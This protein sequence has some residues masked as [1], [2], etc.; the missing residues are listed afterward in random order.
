M[1]GHSLSAMIGF[2]YMYTDHLRSDI[3]A[4]GASSDKVTT[5]NAAPDLIHSSTNIT[6]EALLGAF[7]RV[8]YDYDEKYLFSATFRA[9]GSSR[10]AEE[11]RWGFFPGG[12]AAWVISEEPLIQRINAI[13]LLKLRASYGLTGNNS[14]GLYDA[15]GVYNLSQSYAG[16]AG[17]RATTMP[18][19]SLQW[20]TT[21]QLD[22]GLDLGLFN[23]RIV[24]GTDYFHKLTDDLLFTVPLPNTTGF[25]NI[26][27]N[28]GQ[29]KYEGFEVE[30]TSTNVQT[31]RFSWTS[32]LT[33][34][35]VQN[36]VVKLP[37][38]GVEK[39]R[40]G[41]WVD[42]NGNRFGGIAEGEPLA[43]IYAPKVSHIIQTPEQLE[44]AHYD[45]S[46]SGW[47][48]DDGSFVTGRKNLGDYDW[49][50]RDGDGR[51]TDA[52]KFNVGNAI[53]HTTGG[54]TNTFQ[55]NKWSLNIVFDWAIGHSIMDRAY[56]WTFLGNFQNNFAMSRE[57][58]DNSWQEPGDTNVK[59]ARWQPVEHQLNNNFRNSDMFVYKADYLAV[60]EITLGYDFS[61]NLAQ[62]IGAQNIN[63]YASANNLHYFTRVKGVSP[64]FGT[65]NTRGSNKGY[66]MVRKVTFGLEIAF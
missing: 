53:P 24:L 33:L 15:Y 50:D 10:F 41:G 3:Q 31:D 56:L 6:E 43:R 44:N 19:Q 11:N 20:E 37:D 58:L 17:I 59:Y 39:N 45:E 12:S 14:V 22:V 23:D 49:V 52:D 8:M 63:V 27:Q 30:V 46:S 51:I 13:S 47:S 2:S 9:D 57:L 36:E 55:Y 40:I 16:N 4:S 62:R 5:I 38:N 61:P 1:G 64:E 60:R 7:G 65:S 18:N 26:I 21:R 25:N 54:L 34:G 28:V 29:V 66:P 48:P 42:V 32:D 35:Y